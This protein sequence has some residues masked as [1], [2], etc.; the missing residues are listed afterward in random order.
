MS[1]SSPSDVSP[2]IRLPEQGHTVLSQ[3]ELA[4]ELTHLNHGSYGA[5]PLSVRAEQE[6]WRA[7]VERDP[8]GFFQEVYPAAIR[9]SAH[10]VA[11]CFGCA[12]DDW[13]FCENA[14]VAANSVLASLPL[15]PGDEVLTTS[16]AYGAVLKA[17]NIWAARREARVKLAELPPIVESDDQVVELVTSAFTGRTKLL[18]IDHITSRT[19]T[20]LPVKAIAAAARAAGI[21]V[22][23]DG[24]H[25]PGQVPLDVTEIGADWYTGNAH[26]WFFAPRG[27][28]LLWTAPERQ[29][30][31]LPVVLSHGSDAGYTAAFDWVGT[32]DATPWLSFAAAKAAHDHFGGDA[33]MRRNTV[34]A[35]EAADLLCN[36]LDATPAAPPE[37]RAAMAAL[38][39]GQFA[40]AENRALALRRD[41]HRAGFVVPV[42]AAGDILYLRVSAQ[43]YNEIEDYERCAE[44]A[45]RLCRLLR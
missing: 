3:F 20:V 2:E 29:S 17:I 30:Q 21:A 6:R 39:L 14:T 40:D 36:A 27:C 34:L 1:S 25:G 23:V 22:F 28:G 24:A 19:A 26:K 16:H 35:A 37:M 38:C 11:G 43:T 10:N 15:T 18:V 9:D 8:T 12:G 41:L 7:R 44:A 31:T 42:S 32:R 4:P 13:V 45:R 33:L 5:L